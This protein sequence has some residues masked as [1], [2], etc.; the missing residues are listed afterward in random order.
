MAEIVN[1]VAEMMCNDTECYP[2]NANC[3][4]NGNGLNCS[5]LHGYHGKAGL[6]CS[7]SMYHRASNNNFKHM[8]DVLLLT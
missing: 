8:V 2:D 5:C 6:N 3:T 1:E 7:K 4:D